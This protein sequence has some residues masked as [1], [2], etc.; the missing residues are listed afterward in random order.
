MNKHLH[1]L[2]EN[3]LKDNLLFE[4]INTYPNEKQTLAVMK[5]CSWRITKP[6]RNQSII[7]VR[8]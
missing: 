2:P 4:K 7:P 3:L 8:L 6:D 5:E 1:S